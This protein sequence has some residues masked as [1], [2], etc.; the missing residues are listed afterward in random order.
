MKTISE[1]DLFRRLAFDNPWWGFNPETEIK[2]RH[3]PRRAF[4][5]AFSDRVM[6]TESGEVLVLAGPLRSGFRV[7]G[8]GRSV[9][10]PEPGFLFNFNFKS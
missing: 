6:A 3:P 1:G 9:P 10:E 7:P 4:F 5:P 2:F 8:A